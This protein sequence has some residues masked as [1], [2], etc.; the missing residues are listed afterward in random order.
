MATPNLES[1]ASPRLRVRLRSER[2]EMRSK[3]WPTL[4][5]LPAYFSLPANIPTST[6]RNTTPLIT[7]VAAQAAA[8]GHAA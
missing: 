6:R 1:F 5:L 8:C 3:K 4:L 7:N 2:R